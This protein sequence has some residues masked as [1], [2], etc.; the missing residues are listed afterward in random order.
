[1]VSRVSAPEEAPL[2]ELGFLLAAPLQNSPQTVHGTG[3]HM[4]SGGQGYSIQ[5][6]FTENIAST[7]YT[8]KYI[9]IY[10]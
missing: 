10:I 7:S 5:K 6:P 9:Y 4:V 1:M 3:N 8:H 2:H